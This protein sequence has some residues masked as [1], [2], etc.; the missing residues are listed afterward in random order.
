M[1]WSFE[2]TSEKQRKSATSKHKPT[3]KARKPKAHEKHAVA[4]HKATKHAVKHEEKPSHVVEKVH[5]KKGPQHEKGKEEKHEEIEK[6]RPHKGKVHGKGKKEVEFITRVPDGHPKR[7][8]HMVN[9]YSEILTLETSIDRL[10][11]LVQKEGQIKVRDAAKKFNVGG[12]LVEEWGRV[13]ESH[14]LV[15]MHYPA[16]GELVIR[17]KQWAESHKI[18]KHKAKK[19]E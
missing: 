3:H 16:F 17:S 5:K 1:K 4:V 6:P 13:L 19:E 10:Y 14:D 9:D 7:I 8:R 15:E 2:M 11:H 18:G 12:D